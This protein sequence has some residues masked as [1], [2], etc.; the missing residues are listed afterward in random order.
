MNDQRPTFW[1]CSADSSRNAEPAPR[2][3]RKAETGVS[4]S[5]M[6]VW[7]SGIRRWPPA[8]ARTR[9]SSSEGVITPV[10]EAMSA[11][12][13]IEHL[14]RV[15]QAEAAGGQQDLEVVQDVGGLLGDALVGLLARGADDLLGLL[16]HLLAVEGLVGEQP[17]R[18]GRRRVGGGAALGDRAL[19]GGQRL[20]R[21][22]R[23]EV[24]VVE[25][26]ARAGVARRAGGL[27]QGED[28]VVVAVD[29]Q[30]PDLLDVA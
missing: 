19:E 20:V 1:P 3:L 10:S 12:T 11:A 17:G 18:V 27:D 30:R 7:V 14:R 4:V 5:S 29:A 24:P 22:G 16:L 2:S 28:G 6:T 9:T 21:R 26:R 8:P 13:A 15:A 23:L 25:T